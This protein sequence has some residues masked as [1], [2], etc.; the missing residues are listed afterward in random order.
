ML[1][2]LQDLPWLVSAILPKARLVTYYVSYA[3]YELS[4]QN[5]ELLLH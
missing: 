1:S 5:A 3:V 4:V 2:S